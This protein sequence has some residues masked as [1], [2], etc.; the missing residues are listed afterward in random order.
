MYINKRVAIVDLLS[1]LTNKCSLLKIFSRKMISFQS[2][3]L[4]KAI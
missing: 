1:L 2:L 4:Y 3:L